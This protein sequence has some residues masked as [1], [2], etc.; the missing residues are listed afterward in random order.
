MPPLSAG[1]AQGFLRE[2]SGQLSSAIKIE[3]GKVDLNGKLIPLPPLG[4]LQR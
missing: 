3:A 4:M 1:I 2:E